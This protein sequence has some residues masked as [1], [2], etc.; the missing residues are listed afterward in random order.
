MLICGNRGRWLASYTSRP[1]LRFCLRGLT[2]RLFSVSR[3]K[4]C[5]RL[6]S[7]LKCATT[8]LFSFLLHFIQ[9]LAVVWCTKN[10]RILRGSLFVEI[11]HRR[12]SHNCSV[13]CAEEF[14]PLSV[15]LN[16]LVSERLV[17]TIVMQRV[18]GNGMWWNR[19]F[20]QWWVREG[21]C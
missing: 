15:W 18:L 4:S 10:R 9:I 17:S 6:G 1:E 19:C 20:V 12:R 3:R 7:H 16:W 11:E 2:H 5:Y 14:L 21:V 8:S 13:N